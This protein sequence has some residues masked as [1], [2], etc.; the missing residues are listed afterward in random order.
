M[1]GT[2]CV[3]KLSICT[4]SHLSSL[5]IDHL[6]Q[7]HLPDGKKSYISL[8][9]AGTAVFHALIDGNGPNSERNAATINRKIDV[10][11]TGRL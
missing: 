3:S 9:N 8:I 7:L 11:F 10:F 6:T 1:I 4:S 2:I 5:Q